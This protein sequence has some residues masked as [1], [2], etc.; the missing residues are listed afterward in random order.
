MNSAWVVCPQSRAKRGKKKEESTQ[1][2]GTQGI[3]IHQVYFFLA[4]VPKLKQIITPTLIS[5]IEFTQA[6]FSL[7]DS[8]TLTFPMFS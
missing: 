4:F 7:W 2:Q 5:V 1:P 8:L 3:L 6:A